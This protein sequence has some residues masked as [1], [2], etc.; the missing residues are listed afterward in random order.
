MRKK[1]PSPHLIQMP[2]DGQFPAHVN[3]TSS[4]WPFVYRGG[5]GHA[6][7][8]FSY[9]PPL[10]MLCP[11]MLLVFGFVQSQAYSMSAFKVSFKHQPK[12]NPQNAVFLIHP[13]TGKAM[14]ALD[15]NGVLLMFFAKVGSFKTCSDS[16]RLSESLSPIIAKYFLFESFPL[17]ETISFFFFFFCFDNATQLCP[18]KWILALTWMKFISLVWRAD[19]GQSHRTLLPWLL[20]AS[21]KRKDKT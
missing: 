16:R 8:C 3:H 14:L 15:G 1:K 19:L 20:R 5:K 4:C 6:W 7:K 18:E 9:S 12:S 21:L 2:E 11:I 10:T 13:S 17:W